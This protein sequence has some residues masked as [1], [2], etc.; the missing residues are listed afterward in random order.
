VFGNNALFMIPT[1]GALAGVPLCFGIGPMECE[2]CGPTFTADGRS[3]LLAVQHPG[4][5]HGTRGLPGVDQPLETTR[6][7][8]VAARDGTVFTQERVVPL[9]SNFPHRRPGAP[10]LPC[11]VCITRA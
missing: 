7:M 1:S 6:P 3:L 11:V 5:L 10:P 8:R 4:E 9:G 2:L